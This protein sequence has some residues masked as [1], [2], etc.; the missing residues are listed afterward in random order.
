VGCGTGQYLLAVADLL[1]EG[2]GIDISP[3]MVGQARANAGAR[4]RDVLRFEVGSIEDG[5]CTG[6]DYDMVLFY[7]SIE[8]LD[9]PQ[10]ALLRAARLLRPNGLIVV[11]MLN[12][13][14]PRSRLVTRALAAGRMPPLRLVHPRAV[15]AWVSGQGLVPVPLHRVLLR[16]RRVQGPLCWAAAALKARLTGSCVLVLS[17]SG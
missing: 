1:D 7:G 14:H 3:M 10:A 11:S 2:V 5:A 15:Q 8:H 6:P 17:R 4:W 9:D 12:G 13:S 16:S